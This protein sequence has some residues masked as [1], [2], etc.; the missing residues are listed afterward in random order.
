MLILVINCGSSSAKY[1][2]FDI[3][4]KKVLAK[5]VI[6]RIGQHGSCPDHSAAIA[7]IVDK[8]TK[9]PG[10]AISSVNQISGIGHRVVHGGEEFKKATLLTAKVIKS[11]EKYSELAPLHNPPSL[12]GIRACSRILRGIP[13]VAVFDTAFHQT[14]PEEA[15]LYGLPYGYYKKY[16]I[17]RYG[18]HGTSHRFVSEEASR[19]LRRKASKLK[20]VTCHLGN[21]CSMAAV[22]GG[23]SIDTS[24]GFT[25]LE[26]LLMGTRSGD[27]DP[28]A[29]LYIMEKEGLSIGQTSDIL[30]KKSGFLG[31]S[32]L[33]S[34]MRDI[35]KGARGRG[36][37]AERCKIAIEIFIYRIKKYIGAYQAAMGGLDAVIFTA[38][39]GEN[40]PW[41]LK[42]IAA[43]LKDVVRRTTKFLIIPTNE[44]LLI[45]HDTYEII[46]R[47]RN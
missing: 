11:I 42:R 41:I 34:D 7:S 46:E 35:L 32:G 1:Q 43:E 19:V 18:F 9:G 8:L 31:V 23:R 12:A 10:R 6:E 4:K 16:G 22:A 39:V 37:K 29:V 38:G 45:A 13:Q 24:M 17:R 21:G 26:G 40:N 20:L 5:G 2:L 47:G 36:Q 25:P 3:A 33:A 44:E 15:F 30:N 27:L 28:A 14:M